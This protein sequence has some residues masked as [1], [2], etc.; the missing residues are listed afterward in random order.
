M[1]LGSMHPVHIGS[2]ASH[3]EPQLGVDGSHMQP[4]SVVGSQPVLQPVG[5]VIGS[6]GHWFVDGSHC[7]VQPFG[8]VIGSQVWPHP[9]G[10][11]VGS[12]GQPFGA[13][14]GS[15]GMQPSG[16]VVGS[17]IG[18][19]QLG[20]IGSQVMPPDPEPDPLPMPESLPMP[21]PEPLPTLPQSHGVVGWQTRNDS[22]CA[23][24]AADPVMTCWT[25]LVEVSISR[26]YVLPAGS[27]SVHVWSLR[28]CAAVTTLSS[29]TARI[30]T[31]PDDSA[32]RPVNT[33][34]GLASVQAKRPTV[35]TDTNQAPDIL[36]ICSH[37]K[38]LSSLVPATREAFAE[39]RNFWQQALDVRRGAQ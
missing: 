9:F 26:R 28:I 1:P 24:P 12:Q 22:S 34:D 38:A 29:V 21:E 35:A 19:G 7:I 5:S 6:H 36:I 37:R 18:G 33:C 16:S 4:L 30:A 32:T 8:S 2:F 11:V 10:S 27:D 13:V 23:V 20:S 14:I 17:H 3:V 15:H 39:K 25:P 31:T